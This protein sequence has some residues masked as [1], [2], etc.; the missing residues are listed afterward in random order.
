MFFSEATEV[1]FSY[2]VSNRLKLIKLLFYKI[3]ILSMEQIPDKIKSVSE[4]VAALKA[5][6][7]D[8][9][10]LQKLSVSSDEESARISLGLAFTVNSLFYC[11]S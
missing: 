4:M 3:I 11:K 6:G 7:T 2:E 10:T 5:S 9:E 8:Y 1:L